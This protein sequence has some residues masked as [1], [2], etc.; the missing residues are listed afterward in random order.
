MAA[1]KQFKLLA[2]ASYVAKMQKGNWNDPLLRQVLP[3]N[4]EMQITQ[5]FG[6]DPVGDEQAMVSDGLLHK[7]HGRVLLVTTGA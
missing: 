3:I 5:G 7:Y 2:P 1:N 6:I 4:E